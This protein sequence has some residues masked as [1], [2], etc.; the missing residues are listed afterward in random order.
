MA[1][2]VRGMEEVKKK[3]IIINKCNEM[4]KENQSTIIALQ[5]TH[6]KE[7]DAQGMAI[8]AKFKT[9]NSTNNGDGNRQKKCLVSSAQELV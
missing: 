2:N 4:F 3:K 9:H 5:E 1:Q 7:N 8:M 6:F